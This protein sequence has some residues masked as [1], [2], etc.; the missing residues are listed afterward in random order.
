M[1]RREL[2]KYLGALPFL[3][4]LESPTP[5]VEVKTPLLDMDKL[6]KDLRGPGRVLFE[7]KDIVNFNISTTFNLQQVFHLGQLGLYEEDFP[8]PEIEV[9]LEIRKPNGFIEEFSFSCNS[10]CSRTNE[11]QKTEDI[12]PRDNP[13]LEQG[14]RN[15]YALESLDIFKDD[16]RIKFLDEMN[17]LNGYSMIGTFNNDKYSSRFEIKNLSL[18][19][20]TCFNPFAK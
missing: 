14:K 13:Y 12:I 8:D 10:H 16:K 4:L 11:Q 17:V 2:F 9:E 20:I 5:Q 15:Y 18:G 19:H 7:F 1:L 6:Q 3:G